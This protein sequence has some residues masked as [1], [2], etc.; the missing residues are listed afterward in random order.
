[1]LQLAGI[2]KFYGAKAVFKKISFVLEPGLILLLTGANGAGKSTLLK[3]ISGLTPPSGGSLVVRLREPGNIACLGPQSQMYPELSAAENLAFWNSFYGFSSAPERIAE[4]LE[5]VNLAASAHDKAGAFSLGMLKRLDLA[6]V[7]LLAPALILLDEP[8]SGL[9]ELSQGMLL[10]E[11]NSA[12]AQGASIIWASNALELLLP[13]VRLVAELG[14]RGK[15]KFSELSFFGQAG[16]YAGNAKKD[17]WVHG[18]GQF[19]NI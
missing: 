11:I 18:S 10:K 14:A 19:T 9:D 15:N 12:A 4:V 8:E 6:R 2:S 7:L 13:H 17:V 5:R 1:M 16:E 3:I